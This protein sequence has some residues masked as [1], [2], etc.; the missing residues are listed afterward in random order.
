MCPAT[1][2]FSLFVPAMQSSSLQP[3]PLRRASVAPSSSLSFIFKQSPFPKAL[4]LLT[5]SFQ[6]RG[7]GGCRGKCQVGMTQSNLAAK[8]PAQHAK[9]P[10]HIKRSGVTAGSE[11]A[12]LQAVTG[13]ST[14]GS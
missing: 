7:P 6:R 10:R 4:S 11:G 1:C 14:E 12:Y 8:P 2:C 9:K 3:R 5:N 13:Q